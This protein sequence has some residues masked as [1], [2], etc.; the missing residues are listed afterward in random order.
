MIEREVKNKVL[1]MAEKFPVIVFT[2]PRQSG[3]TT[4]S[5]VIFKNYRYVSLENPDVLYFAKTDPKGFLNLYDKYVI[6]DEV[7]NAPELFSYLQQIVD[8]SKISGQYILSGSQNFLLFEKI[9]QSLAGRV[10]M[11]ELLPLSHHEIK[12]VKKQNVFEE[13]YFGGYPRLY[14]KNIHPHDFYS[15]YIQTYIE[16]DIRNI[17]NVQ[18][19]VLFRKFVFLL[20]HHVGQLLNTN[21]ISKNLGIDIKTVKRW[22]SILETSYIIFTLPPWHKNFSKRIIKSPKLYFYDVGLASFLLGIENPD[23]LLFS[24]YKG[25]LFENYGLLEI[26]KNHKNK[27]LKKNYYFWKDSYGNEIDLIIEQGQKIKLVELKASETVKSEYIKSLHYLDTLNELNEK[28]ILQH[29]LL[30][31]QNNSEKRTKETIVSWSETYL[32]DEDL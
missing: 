29:Y 3:K 16:R 12:S 32:I 26:L 31:T 1:E 7:Q 10:Y 13:M 5:K 28:L 22:L 9:T 15:S 6:I 17:I 25:A 30:N 27:G 20:A 14:D 24:T 19:L 11:M 4:V 21:S 23:D 18:D 8:D 2:G